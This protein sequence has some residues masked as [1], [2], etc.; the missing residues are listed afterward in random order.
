M[1]KMNQVIAIE[2]GIK[3]RVYAELSAIYK[4]FQKPALFNGLSRVYSKKDE[5]G[6]DYPAEHTRV[7]R[8][9]QQMLAVMRKDMTE[10][11]DVTARKDFGN[12]AA[13]A[14]L[15]LEDGTVLL[16]EVPATF[17][18][19]LEKQMNDL[20]AEIDKLPELD[21][22]HDWSW[23]SDAEIYKS[24]PTQTTKTK[25][26]PKVLVKFAPTKEHPGQS[27]IYMQDDV[28]GTWNTVLHSG[29]MPA[30]EKRKLQERVIALIKA[31]KVAREQANMTDAP[32]V[33]VGD[34]IFG[35]L[36]G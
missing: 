29:A 11:Y 20:K 7:Q 30:D 12:C 23:S 27:E 2:K 1:A 4:E 24:E 9:V 16:R 32:P 14:D 19:F 10:L 35:Y 3:T 22:S 31:V 28:V 6:E 18:L 36:F 33:E 5:D 13:K 21:P 8:S 26:V 25:K 34:S 17:L 15:K